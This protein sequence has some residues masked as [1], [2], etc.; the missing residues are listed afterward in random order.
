MQI[1]LFF[2]TIIII[3]F[4]TKLKN[5]IIV[6]PKSTKCHINEDCQH[7]DFDNYVTSLSIITTPDVPSGGSF[8]VKNR[9]CIMWAGANES[10]LIVTSTIEWSKSSWLKGK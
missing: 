10:R 3:F 1:I 2:I 6:G 7:R 9:T 8:C 4:R 5:I